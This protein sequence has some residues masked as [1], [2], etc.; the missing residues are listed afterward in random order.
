MTLTRRDV[1]RMSG[2]A[3]AGLSA[4]LLTAEELRSEP[5]RSRARGSAPA[6]QDGLGE[7]EI[8]DRVEFPL[9]PDGSAIEHAESEAGPIEGVLWRYTG[10]EPTRD[11]VRLPKDEC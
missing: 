10:G 8:R 7:V 11:R 3:L 4:G 2:G 6:L 1:I 9:N 5:T